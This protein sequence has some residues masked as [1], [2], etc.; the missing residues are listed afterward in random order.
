MGES[1]HRIE[2]V[3]QKEGRAIFQDAWQRACPARRLPSDDQIDN[4]FGSSLPATRIEGGHKQFRVDT[5]R[6]LA[7]R[8]PKDPGARYIF[9]NPDGP[10][11]HL[12]QLWGRFA[13]GGFVVLG[14]FHALQTGT[15][16]QRRQLQGVLSAQAIPNTRI[17]FER[18][19]PGGG[20]LE[21]RHLLQQVA[22]APPGVSQM[23]ITS[24]LVSAALNG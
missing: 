1:S 20:V 17:G 3:E 6:I 24:H 21:W 14:N 7:D 22:L 8:M 16:L 13:S 5:I 12:H 11:D 15:G 2:W 18:F 19:A 9:A 4:Y 10:W 23:P